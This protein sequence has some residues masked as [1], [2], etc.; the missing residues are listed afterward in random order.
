[1]YANSSLWKC[2]THASSVCC[3]S[4]TANILDFILSS[5]LVHINFSLSVFYTDEVCR[6][7]V[8]LNTW[9]Q[10]L[11]KRNG[12]WSGPSMWV[13]SSCSGPT[14]LILK[15]VCLKVEQD[16]CQG[17][18]CTLKRAHNNWETNVTWKTFVYVCVCV[19]LEKDG[20]NS[21]KCTKSN[22]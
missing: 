1:M 18:P 5:L 10:G 15:S 6:T 21:L 9:F 20:E 4:L 14:L 8:R 11:K 19:S 12:V 2:V 22:F 17:M 3:A 16:S 7:S 13:Q